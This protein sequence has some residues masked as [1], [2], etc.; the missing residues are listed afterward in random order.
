MRTICDEDNEG[1][2]VTIEDVLA[3]GASEKAVLCVIDGEEYWIPKSQITDDSEVYDRGHK[4]KLV[5]TRW[6]AQRRE[7]V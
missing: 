4:G 7:L 3:K 6:L 1:E 5:I 2:P